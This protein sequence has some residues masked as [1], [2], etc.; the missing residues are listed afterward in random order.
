MADDALEKF[1]A[2]IAGVKRALDREEFEKALPLCNKASELQPKN[3]IARRCKL[4]ALLNLSRWSEALQV[5]E[6]CVE[7]EVVAFE[8]AYCFY[9]LNK[10][11]EAL[12]A[13]KAIKN[14][15]YGAGRL[16][17]QV[18]YRMGDYEKCAGMYEKLYDED[19]EDSG[20]L[21]NALASHV[22]GDRPRQAIEA[23]KD[24]QELLESC[25][26]L[27]FNMACALIDE[28]RLT[29]AEE[30]LQ[31]AKRLCTAEIMKAE[32]LNEEDQAS[33]DDHEDLAG[34]HVQQALVLQRR[35][36]TDEANE[37]YSQVLKT[38]AQGKSEVDVTVLAVA[39]NNV[40]TLRS[41]GKSLFDSLKR[42]NIASK[43]SLEQKLTKKQT[44]EIAI[45]KCLLL[46]QAHKLD[47]ARREMGKLKEAY[48]G[49]P[50]VAIVQAAIAYSEKKVK[51]CEEILTNFLTEQPG[52]EEVL[53]ALAQLYE[54][55]QRLD[56]AVEALSQLPLKL[57]ARP[58]T[59]QAI[60]ALYLRQK[61]HEKAVKEFREAI[62]FW[63]AEGPEHE[64]TLGAVL[65]IA[66]RLNLKDQAFAAE[67]FQMYL[68]KIDGSDTDAL[69]GL[70]QALATT[71]DSEKAEQYAMRL[72]VPSYEHLDPEE[73]EKA[74]IPKIDKNLKLNKAKV[75]PQEAEKVAEKAKDKADDDDDE[76]EA[77]EGEEA[78][79]GTVEKVKRK[80]K[81]K[82]RYPKN[83][84]PENPGPPPDPERWLKKNQ[85][86]EF[87]KRMSKRNKALQRGPQ[88]SIPVDDNAFRKQGPSTAQIDV[89]SSDPARG[90]RARNQGKRPKKK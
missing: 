65:Q 52:S 24:Q 34:I 12:E 83:F 50:Q 54:T 32:D 61:N 27:S 36:L 72:K 51:V 67:V 73:L 86:S 13:L 71:G 7:P 58:R 76:E 69:C 70:V 15:S 17:A 77:A 79:E 18:R 49:N 63:V 45:N 74:A 5:Y 22:S 59:L 20:L 80:R 37:I 75:S 30:R 35:G 56:K 4:F 68:E 55:Q 39:C 81:R 85:R 90:G 42:I 44:L 29:A 26:E 48:P 3:D 25:Y 1:E 82:P 84:D 88:G 16:E 23:V 87:L 46:A 40:V 14:D 10:F 47:E 60:V 78:Q 2:A 64:E 38:S 21:V 11:P 66:T 33:L 19:R 31:E 53:L 89:G 43:E 28:N 62:D 57:R 41:D 9:R 8:R 6:K